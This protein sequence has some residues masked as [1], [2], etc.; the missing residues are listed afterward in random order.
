MSFRGVVVAAILATAVG[1]CASVDGSSSFRDNG[2]ISEND[3]L[4]GLNRQIFAAN[5]AVDTFLLRP[6]AVGYRE[7]VPD[8]GKEIIRNFLNNLRAPLILINDLAQGEGAR[9]QTTLSRLMV[10]TVLG[11]GGLFD[12]AS[13]MGLAYHS[14]DVGQTLATYGVDE[15]PYLVLP[16]L[17]PSNARD[18]VGTALGWLIDPVR[19]GAEAANADDALYAR[20]VAEGIDLRYRLMPG[21]DE[22]RRTS[23]DFYA[24]TRS[25]YRQR[26]V[27]QIRNAGEPGGVF[28]AGQQPSQVGHP[29]TLLAEGIA[30]SAEPLLAPD[31]LERDRLAPGRLDGSDPGASVQADVLLA[32]GP[33]SS[34]PDADVTAAP[35]LAEPTVD[36]RFI[37]PRDAREEWPRR[38]DAVPVDDRPASS[39]PGGEAASDVAVAVTPAAKGAPPTVDPL[40]IEPRGASAALIAH[41][42]GPVTGITMPGRSADQ[43]VVERNMDGETQLA[44]VEP[45]AFTRASF[46]DNE[47]LA[48]QPIS[49]GGVEPLASTVSVQP[50]VSSEPTGLAEE[51]LLMHQA[52]QRAYEDALR[53]AEAV[54]RNE[55]VQQ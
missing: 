45:A 18:A 50:E 44:A 34:P 10:N 53:S 46:A 4:E 32:A 16:I 13:S 25:A 52:A 37:E 21:Y 14:E 1:G 24:F 15:G 49:G 20:A 23:L 6:A 42:A 36:P 5:L 51:A 17:G 38:T 47:P 27:Q 54:T 11:V 2:E 22:L 29:E 12:P 26:R 39:V 31:Q 8:F 9:A 3:P 7:I 55:Q 35:R 33:Q 41:A 43:D 28:A 30:G 48:V 19:I 40:F